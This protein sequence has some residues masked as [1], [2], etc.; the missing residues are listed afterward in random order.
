MFCRLSAFQSAETWL[1]CFE[2][3][4]FLC[5]FFLKVT[6][7]ALSKLGHSLQRDLEVSY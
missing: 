6:F 4:N 5:V 3:N 7:D 2:K 1:A